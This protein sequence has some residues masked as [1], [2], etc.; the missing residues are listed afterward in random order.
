MMTEMR[1]A[2][3]VDNG[4]TQTVVLPEDVRFDGDEVIISRDERTHGVLLSAELDPARTGAEMG[5][6][7]RVPKYSRDT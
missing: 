7:L 3:L 4:S 5:G 1:R 2:K 6:I